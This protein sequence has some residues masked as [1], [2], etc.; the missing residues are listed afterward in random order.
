MKMILSSL[1]SF[2]KAKP[3][4]FIEYLM[5]GCVVILAGAT[6]YLW[7]EYNVVNERLQTSEVRIETA[8]GKIETAAKD[9]QKLSEA[10]KFLVEQRNKDNKSYMDLMNKLSAQL[11]NSKALDDKINSL[12]ASNDS[13]KAYLNERIPAELRELLN[14]DHNATTSPAGSNPV[15]ATGASTGTLYSGS[16]AGHGSNG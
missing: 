2:I 3:R 5:I 1:L 10:I 12:E 11:E 6:V 4:L 9:N 15:N 14:E 8:H 7:G 13:V 16:E